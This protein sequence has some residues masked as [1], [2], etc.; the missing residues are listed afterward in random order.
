MPLIEQQDVVI[1]EGQSLEEARSLLLTKL[2]SYPPV[3]IVS[4][5]NSNIGV[6]NRIV[7]VVETL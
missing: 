1:A 5:S 3:R 6:V 2:E 4:I 7:A